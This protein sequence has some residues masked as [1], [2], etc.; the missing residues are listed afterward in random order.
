[1]SRALTLVFAIVCYAIFF[2]TFLYLIGF[3]GDLPLIPRT[4]DAPPSS[5][6]LVAAAV[7]DVALIGLFGLQHSAMARPAFKRAWTRV[8]PPALERS[9]YVLC[10]S[11]A[12]ILLFLLWQP[13]D[14]TVW[15]VS[16]DMRWLSGIL[17]AMFWAGFGIVLVSTF[18]INHF[19]LFGLEQAWLNLRRQEAAAPELRQPLFYRW[20]AH[21][22]YA[23][24]FLAFWA[25]PRMSLGHLLLSVALSIYM[26]IAIRYEEHDLTDLF[27]EDYRRYRSGVGM[28]IPRLRRRSA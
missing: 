1:M 22:L 19:E 20:V 23:G 5:M 25:T 7:V 18:L 10:A 15:S 11:A 14:R 21:P 17:W 28:L 12:L 8:V 26:L 2:A 16:P 9:V 3:V 24:F 6:G 4:V 13:I 27:G